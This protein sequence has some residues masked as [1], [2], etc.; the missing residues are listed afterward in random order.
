[1]RLESLAAMIA[2]TLLSFVR[3]LTASVGKFSFSNFWSNDLCLGS[4]PVYHKGSYNSTDGFSQATCSWNIQG[5][6]LIGFWC[7]WGGNGPVMMIGGG[8]SGCHRADHGIA[9]D[10]GSQ[11]RRVCVV[12]RD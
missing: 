6:N 8:G 2:Q 9:I 5:S 10:Q 7:H 12:T 3:I 11:Q 4:C 1:M